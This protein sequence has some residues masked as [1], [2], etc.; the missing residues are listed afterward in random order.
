MI[1]NLRGLLDN[2]TANLVATAVIFIL[3]L[4]L[5]AALKYSRRSRAHKVGRRYG[6]RLNTSR[7][8]E[9]LYAYYSH[10]GYGG[11]LYQVTTEECRKR[12]AFL[13]EPEWHL[14]VLEGTLDLSFD[15]PLR[16]SETPVDDKTLRALG[17][18]IALTGPDGSP[19]NCPLVSLRKIENDG[20]RLRLGWAEYYQYL[21]TCGKLELETRRAMFR[22]GATPIRDGKFSSPA[23]LLDGKL[24]AQAVGVCA[25]VVFPDQDR[26]FRF[27]LQ[28]RQKNVATYPGAYAVV[29]M[30]GCQPLCDD[31]PER[32]SLKHDLLR[33]FGE[34][35][36][37]IPELN[38]PTTHVRYDWF[39]DLPPIRE[40]LTLESSGELH[41]AT[42]GFGLDG[43]NG[44]LDI[45]M[46]CIFETEAFFLANRGAMRGNWEIK[47]VETPELFSSEVDKII[48]GDQCHPGSAFAIDLARK[49]VRAKGSGGA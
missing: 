7:I 38:H 32:I 8:A 45:A 23:M 3:G 37:S 1:D 35:L 2:V 47:N 21:S 43:L 22:R 28:R 42:L 36:F 5:R 19:W 44:E 18:E 14:P 9:W 25:C 31:P 41:I 6:S 15:T 46:V 40:L 34:E 20:A 30:F 10:R 11:L 33:E 48:T 16:Q 17:N 13:V 39:Y 27:L 26:G 4:T 12:I 49:F 24:G 29:P